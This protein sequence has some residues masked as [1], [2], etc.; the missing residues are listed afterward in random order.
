MMDLYFKMVLSLLFVLVILGF[1][2]LVIRKRVNLNNKGGLFDI[3]EYKS[4][5][6]KMGIM[7]LK[8][9][10]RVLLIALTS[11]NITLIEQFDAKNVLKDENR[12]DELAQKIKKLRDGLNEP[13]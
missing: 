7:A 9:G 4:F 8:F 10:D 3:L 11:T 6:P 5:G 1:V 12:D 13:N 2:Y